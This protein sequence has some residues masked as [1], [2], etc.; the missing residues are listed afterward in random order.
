M[1][2]PSGR[3]TYGYYKDVHIPHYTYNLDDISPVS[4]LKHL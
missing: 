1:G 2:T 4:V 3:R